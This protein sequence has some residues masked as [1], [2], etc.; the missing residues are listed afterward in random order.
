MEHIKWHTESQ[1]HDA[2][3]Q[4]AT[5][6]FPRG[7]RTLAKDLMLQTALNSLVPLITQPPKNMQSALNSLVPLA[8]CILSILMPTSLCVN[9]PIK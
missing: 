7:E 5:W 1:T 8:Y 2:R 3:A 4:A 6:Q 9:S